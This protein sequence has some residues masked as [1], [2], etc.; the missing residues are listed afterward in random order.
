MPYA[1][2]G[3]NTS[4]VLNAPVDA[5]PQAPGLGVGAVGLGGRAT[6][7][8]IVAQG[9][10]CSV[11][12]GGRIATVRKVAQGGRLTVANTLTVEHDSVS[13]G[14]SYT[15]VTITRDYTLATGEAPVGVVYFT[16]STWMVNNAVTIPA[17]PVSAVLSSEGLIQLT[18]AANNDVGTT[19]IGSHYEVREQITGQLTR[20]YKVAVPYNAGV[21]VD[22]STLPIIP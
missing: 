22:L 6:Q 15:Y 21:T 1:W 16:P 5:G 8:K 9:G 13:A 18:L 14:G 4:L 12:A 10:Q 7:K 17:A 19:P 3:A 2:R 20:I 11:A